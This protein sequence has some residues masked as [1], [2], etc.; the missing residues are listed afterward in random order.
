M[1]IGILAL[2][3]AFIEHESPLKKWGTEVI[4]VKL[5]GHLEGLDGLIIPG[6]ESTT[7]LNLLTS[8]GLLNPLKK[9]SAE[10]F[11][12]WGICAGTICLAK[13]INNSNGSSSPI[14]DAM[15]ITVIRNAFGRQVNSFETDVKIDALGD[16]PFHAV[17]IRA[18][19][20][21]KAQPTVDILGRLD[22][23]S[24]IAARQANLLATTFHPELTDDTRMHSYFLDMVAG[25]K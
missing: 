9:L 7:M 21:S 4:R 17:F 13:S 20:I 1:K 8:S 11:P 5:P 15:D 12:I 6:G 14:L 10:C 16:Q 23:G 22:N 24:I 2:Q 25:V 3:G 18:P 19:V